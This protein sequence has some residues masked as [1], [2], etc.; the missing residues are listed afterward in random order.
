MI[1]AANQVAAREER[2]N[3]EVLSYIDYMRKIGADELIPEMLIRNQ[4]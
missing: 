2:E 1:T 4:R 3:H